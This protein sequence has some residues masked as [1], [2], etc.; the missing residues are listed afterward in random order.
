M[1]IFSNPVSGF[2]PRPL[3]RERRRN[4]TLDICCNPG[5]NPRPLCRERHREERM[6]TRLLLVSIHA[7]YAGSDLDLNVPV[8]EIYGFNPRP[9]CRERRIAQPVISRKHMFQSTPPMQGATMLFRAQQNQPYVSIH[10]PYAGSDRRHS[11]PSH[12]K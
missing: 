10:A 3:C 12:H 9:L 11:S 8:P 4:R 1:L 5:F 2:N 6:Q 7:P